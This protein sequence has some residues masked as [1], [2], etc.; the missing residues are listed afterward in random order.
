MAIAEPSVITCPSCGTRNR[1]EAGRSGARCG[2]CNTR[3]PGARTT[4]LELSD[5]T[6][7][8][9]VLDSD[10]PVLVDLWA[11]WC[12]PCRMLAPTIEAL[13]R[14]HAGV[15]KVCKL[16]TER[17]PGTARAL[18]VTGIPTLVVFRHGKLVGRQTGV[19]GAPQ[20]E[21]WLRQ[22]GVVRDT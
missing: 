18:N 4:P 5:A 22:L 10:Q 20:L 11:P 13:A 6:F 19:L 17:N 14:R 9:E 1:V 21:A 16:D 8:A 15:L 12:G 3:L 2:R 7:Q